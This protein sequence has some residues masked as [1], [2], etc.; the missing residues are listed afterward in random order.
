[1]GGFLFF[2]FHRL[3]FSLS[4]SNNKGVCGS[5]FHVGSGVICWLVG[6]HILSVMFVCV[7]GAR[8]SPSYSFMSFNLKQQVF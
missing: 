8:H 5:I 2:I 1:M 6:G 4:L 7:Q 3:V